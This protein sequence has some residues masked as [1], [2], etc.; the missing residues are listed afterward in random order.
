MRRDARP[1]CD[2]TT[3]V[4]E[5]HARGRTASGVWS[6]DTAPAPRQQRRMWRAIIR[7]VV[8]RRSRTRRARLRR[9]RPHTR[10]FRKQRAVSQGLLRRAPGWRKRRPGQSTRACLLAAMCAAVAGVRAARAASHAGRRGAGGSSFLE[11]ATWQHEPQARASG[12]CPEASWQVIQ[13]GRRG[14]R[15]LLGAAGAC[16]QPAV[17]GANAADAQRRCRACRRR[18]ARWTANHAAIAM[19]CCACQTACHCWRGFRAMLW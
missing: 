3:R 5:P 9:L 8:A 6:P 4:R 15:L 11:G 14:Q 1:P 7:T 10:A 17:R 19:A 13:A 12:S 2:T 16:A 18:R